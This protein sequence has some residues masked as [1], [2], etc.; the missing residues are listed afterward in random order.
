MNIIKYFFV[1]GVAAIVDISL[2]GLFAKYIGFNY[3]IVGFF[4][5]IIA[6]GVNY[7]LSIR[8]VFASGSKH[9]KRREISL[10]YLISTVGLGINLLALFIC[11]DWLNIELMTSKVIATGFTFFWNY[12][13][14]KFV[15][16][17]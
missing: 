2:F 3:L 11:H 5:F 14:R 12:F 1:G 6:T 15:V 10:V 4:T 17:N 9:S 13:L 16:F 7:F 8:Y